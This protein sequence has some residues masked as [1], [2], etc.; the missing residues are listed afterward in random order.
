MEEASVK[1]NPTVMI[2]DDDSDIRECLK[3]VLE[4]EGY[5]TINAENG[6]EAFEA[7]VRS[8]QKPKLILLDLMMPVLDAAGFIALQKASK[9]YADI[10]TVIMSACT[11][12]DKRTAPLE[13][14]GHIK[15]PFDF[16]VLLETVKN[17]CQT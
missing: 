8:T 13:I 12:I 15:K 7:L 17:Y 1:E 14:A 10:P 9:Q 6:K 5:S 3:D 16:D 4:S 2:V 11:L